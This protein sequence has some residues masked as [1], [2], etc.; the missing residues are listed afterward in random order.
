LKV[1][2]GISVKDR[3]PDGLG[4]P[5]SKFHSRMGRP[6]KR[7]PKHRYEAISRRDDHHEGEGVTAVQLALID[8]DENMARYYKLDVQPT[9][10]GGRAVIRIGGRA[11]IRKWGRIGRGGTVPSKPYWHCLRSA[12]A[13]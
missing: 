12:V 10:F 1:A 4:G 8:P 3:G 7:T 13:H 2:T 6:P 9:L 5:N 11:V